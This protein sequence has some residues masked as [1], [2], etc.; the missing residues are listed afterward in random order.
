MTI[1]VY[2]KRTR[3]YYKYRGIERLV[4]SSNTLEAISKLL[5]K[6]SIYI[7]V[8][9]SGHTHKGY[10]E[11]YSGNTWRT[12]GMFPQLVKLLNQN[13]YC[14]SVDIIRI[15]LDIIDFWKTPGFIV[16][17]DIW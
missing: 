10:L 1:K 7:K 14:E 16:I 17:N 4:S 8:S 2:K 13:P 3:W 5:G 11:P 9:L 6:R 12:S 15:P